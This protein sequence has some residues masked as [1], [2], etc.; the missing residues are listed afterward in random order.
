M[1]NIFAI[2]A[3]NLGRIYKIR[4]R[5]KSEPK[6]LV[7]LQDVNLSNQQG[8]LFGLLD[9]NGAGKRRMIKSIGLKW[10]TI[11]S[12]N[13]EIKPI[14]HQP[15]SNYLSKSIYIGKLPGSP[16]GTI[17]LAVSERKLLAVGLID[18]RDDFIRDIKRRQKKMGSFHYSEEITHPPQ[19]LEASIMQ[20]S[21]YLGGKRRDFD[22]P[23]DWSLMTPFQ[24]QVLR[25]TV[26]IPYGGVSTYSEIAQKIEKPGAARAVG[27]AEA[28]NPVP[29]VIPCH[30][31]I[32]SD[33]KLHGYGGRG[34]I[35]T[36][37]WLLKLEGDNIT[38]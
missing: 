35:T 5:K 6:V 12:N 33:G 36:K 22:L 11:M 16:I 18:S 17:Y 34:G 14:N 27:S 2:R 10:R 31:V 28:A 26:S 23:I 38:D 3:E 24:E 7:A 20:I 8:E 1:A 37:A 19:I 32:G 25:A 30:R 15:S 9:P 29:I 4:S 13:S 21:E